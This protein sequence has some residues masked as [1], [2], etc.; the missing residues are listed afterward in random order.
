MKIL[1]VDD[2]AFI[3]EILNEAI[4]A[5]GGH[6]I[7]LASSGADALAILRDAVDPFDC[8]LLDI[9]MP[10]M[11]GVELCKLIRE[12]PE[13]SNA[14]ILMITAMSD[15]IHV[16]QSFAAGATDYVTKPFDVV[17]LNSRISFAEQTIER[18]NR[19][20]Q[21]TGTLQ[22][23][24]EQ[25]LSGSSFDIA[26][27]IPLSDVPRS[28][29]LHAFEN[30][31]QQIRRTQFFSTSIFAVGVANIET[32]YGRSSGR[33]FED[34]INDIAESIAGAMRGVPGFLTYMGNGV[35]C[36][37]I[38][39]KYREILSEFRFELENKT[40]EL[41]LIYRN[42]KPVDV[43]YVVGAPVTP[44]LFVRGKVSDILIK[45]VQKMEVSAGSKPTSAPVTTWM[46]EH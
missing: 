40:S 15:K 20:A 37:V 35:F 26:D 23:V 14:P 4:S 18:T 32:I 22:L 7:V 21:N 31:L 5:I 1:A 12:Q 19:P 24:V 41:E 38:E 16:D 45:A 6:D 27:V 13:Y 36:C 46:H 10:E 11:T 28:L 17:E 33:E 2:D 9:Q 42:G 8:F 39:V 29:N 34:H 25:L 30:Y 44:G 43:K 3:L